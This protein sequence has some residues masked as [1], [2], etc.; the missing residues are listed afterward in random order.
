MKIQ[1][2]AIKIRLLKK[3]MI[4]IQ[5]RLSFNH[6]IKRVD[7]VISQIHEKIV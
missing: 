4:I 1:V 7:I 5:L 3:S 2:R 6:L